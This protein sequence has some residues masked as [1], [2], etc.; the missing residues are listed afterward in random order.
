DFYKELIE[1][2]HTY[3]EKGLILSSTLTDQ[4]NIIANTNGLTTLSYSYNSI[5]MI[6]EILMSTPALNAERKFHLKLVYDSSKRLIEKVSE[7]DGSVMTTKYS[8]NSEDKVKTMEYHDG[9]S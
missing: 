3:S 1:V 2:K 6:S 4:N 8:Y 5:G 9:Q 7:S